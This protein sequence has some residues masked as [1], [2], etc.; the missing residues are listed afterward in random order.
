MPI[1]VNVSGVMP[2]I[3]STM[4]F[5]IIALIATFTGWDQNYVFSQVF[6]QGSAWYC[7]I[8]IILI[9]ASTF[10]Y[11]EISFRTTDVAKALQNNEGVIPGVLP[12]KQTE[13][14]LEKVLKRLN[15]ISAVYLSLT[16]LIPLLVYNLIGVSFI[17]AT[18][19][20][21][22]IGTML[23]FV[24]KAKIEYLSHKSAAGSKD[25]ILLSQITT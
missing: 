9:V 5:Q 18:S 17:Q 7:V 8:M 24:K 3:F 10:F 21:I 4:F 25:S 6:T 12:G 22:I 13:E 16:A 19:V 15:I 20:M 1:K 14:Y 23:D 11:S 2:V